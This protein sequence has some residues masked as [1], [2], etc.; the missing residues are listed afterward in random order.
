MKSRSCSESL[1]KRPIAKGLL[2]AA[3]VKSK[4]NMHPGEA[5]AL[6]CSSLILERKLKSARLEG[7]SSLLRVL[8]KA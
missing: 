2:V 3:G 5:T 1:R 8:R 6:G 7:V 4:S